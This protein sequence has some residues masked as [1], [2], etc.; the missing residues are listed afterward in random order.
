MSKHSIED[1]LALKGPTTEFLVPLSANTYK[2]RFQA[3]KIRDAETNQ[4]F[5]EVEKD[6]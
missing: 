6:P 5:F 1:I 3:F 4:V 2:I